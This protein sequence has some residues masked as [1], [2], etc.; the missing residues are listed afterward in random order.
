MSARLRD[1]LIEMISISEAHIAGV[2]VHAR[3]SNIERIRQAIAL[4]LG[5]EIH[6]VNL[7]GKMVITVAADPASEIMARLETIYALPG[8]NSAA[9]VDPHRGDEAL[10]EDI[11]DEADPP[12]VY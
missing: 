9:L 10:D 5:S 11:R 3:Q 4:F 8:V 6:P 12:N 7:A 1:A 2:V